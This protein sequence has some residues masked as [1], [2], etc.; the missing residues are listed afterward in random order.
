MAVPKKRKT[1]FK[2]H[3][4]LP[5]LKLISKENVQYTCLNCDLKNQ[6]CDI[7]DCKKNK[8]IIGLVIQNKYKQNKPFFNKLKFLKKQQKKVFN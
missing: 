3:Q 6:N 1:I 7:K 8:Y 4:K 5:F 2:K